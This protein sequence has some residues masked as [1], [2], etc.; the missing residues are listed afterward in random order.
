MTLIPR[1]GAAAILSLVAEDL[2]AVP[3]RATA[4][5]VRAMAGDPA[6]RSTHLLDTA[7]AALL[8]GEPKRA[9][10]ILDEITATPD[11]ASLS[12]RVAALRSWAGQLDWNWYP[13]NLGSEVARTVPK[14]R[15]AT[16]PPETVL[17]E[18]VVANGPVY[19]LSPRAIIA[20]LQG[21]G[22][23]TAACEM[24][25]VGIQRLE[26]LVSF[27]QGSRI[28]G[29]ALWARLAQADL[30]ERTGRS[31]LS[32]AILTDVR[33][34]AANLGL[35]AILAL[36]HLLEG[37]WAATPSSSPEAMAF[38]LAPRPTPTPQATPEDL[39]RAARCV[40]AAEETAASF[41]AVSEAPAL[42]AGVHL[43]WATLAWLRGDLTHRR[44]SLETA[45]AAAEAAGATA[46]VT[47]LDIHMLVADLAEGRLGE[48]L[49]D[50][51]SGWGPAPTGGRLE[52]V[53]GWATCAG[54]TSWCV[55]L[56]R[57]LQ[58]AGD[59]WRASADEE[60]ASLAYLGAR[61][62]LEIEP[63]LPSLTL[64]T[65]V[66]DLDAHRNLTGR[67]LARLERLLTSL[68]DLTDLRSQMSGA[69]QEMEILVSMVGA[70]RSRA[71]T[72]AAEHA[73][74]GL[75][76]LSARL[77]AIIEFAQTTDLAPKTA[78]GFTA[79]MAELRGLIAGNRQADLQ[80]LLASAGEDPTLLRMLAMLVG[81]AQDQ[82]SMI[83]VLVQLSRGE[84]AQRRGLAEDAEQYYG[85]AL[86]AAA[87][88][89][90]FLAALVMIAAG[91]REEARTE[92]GRL[93]N[94]GALDDDLLALLA[95]RADDL[96]SARAA[97]GRSGA[98]P[99]QT[100]DWRTAL[101]GAE[102][103][104]NDP[105]RA[106]QLAERGIALFEDTIAHLIRDT[107]RVA[108]C[109]D[110]DVAALYLTATRACLELSK[111]EPAA[112]DTHL[113]RAFQWTE[114]ARSLALEQLLHG[115]EPGEAASGGIRSWRE[116]AATWSADVD[117]LLVG[118]DTSPPPDTRPLLR[119]LDASES[120][121]REIEIS[122]DRTTPGLLVRRSHPGTPLRLASVQERLPQGTALLEY[123]TVGDDLIVSA[124]TRD[125]VR[126]ERQEVRSRDLAALV[127]R[128]HERCKDGWGNG[129]EADRLAAL[130]LKPVADIVR[131]HQRLVVVPFGPLTLVPMHALPLGGTPLGLTHV[132]SYAPAA[133]VGAMPDH[134]VRRDAAAVI[135]D[136]AFDTELRPR[137]RRLPGARTEALT[138]AALLG[139]NDVLTDVDATESAARELL[140]GQNV[141]HLATHGWVDELAPYASSLVLAGQDEL[142]VAE[143]V[144]LRLGAD[145]AVLSACDTGRGAA[146][147]GGDLIGL[148]RALLAAGVRG[149]VVSLWPVDD[150]T[151][152]VTM[153]AFYERLREAPPAYALADAQRL[154]HGLD[155]TGLGNRYAQLC[156]EA[157]TLSAAP[158]ERCYRG[159][160]D[161][162][163]P[164]PRAPDGSAERHWAPFVLIGAS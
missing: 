146:T 22:N 41:Q 136:P 164:V 65:A 132:V 16:G 134:I 101:T 90:A 121:L 153:A 117:R 144:G 150:M 80:Q 26:A 32:S 19:L 156:R 52:A 56:G 25:D 120:R 147:L 60:R 135:G 138:V 84:H 87:G 137:L 162:N 133:T 18:E 96:E 95:L 94:A 155:L 61:Q 122:L 148:T 44:R 130:L 161:D 17:V 51:G 163:E 116:A 20:G 77:K 124:V 100:G 14:V 58:R 159:E 129:Q 50:I 141:I 149:T 27:A 63:A 35:P 92:V 13:G 39:D 21:Q 23:E 98:D 36:C 102:L 115:D 43:R 108:A 70:Q 24:A 103:A 64:A 93:A 114:R 91:R 4:E 46:F 31:D 33:A 47:L 38:Q 62:L 66:A 86:R 158:A 9:Q 104:R 74:R 10:R 126:M 28:W 111:R 99:D 34:A 142:I 15:P 112:G 59:H 125:G 81:Q 143:L 78:R 49:R 140:V 97:F 12:R 109:D 45:R 154:V 2:L 48:C 85:A 127:R 119:R 152:C 131:A 113:G 29:A 40:A 107:D 30:A 157:G 106:L 88:A 54:S 53:L 139:T 89:D 123:H 5:A 1:P 83:E 151:A 118:I 105:G 68:P 110:P 71:R 145:L 6:H 8:A 3:G 82:R 128:H 160:L 42:W 37:D 55:G 75:E 7:Y 57:L 79:D 72:A 67:A 76:R 69:A 11:G 73:A